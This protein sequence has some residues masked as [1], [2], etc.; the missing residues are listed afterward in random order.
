VTTLSQLDYTPYQNR[1]IAVVNDRVVGVG[2]NADQAYRSAKQVRPKDRPQLLFVDEAGQAHIQPDNLGQWFENERLKQIALILQSQSA[3]VYLVGGAV[4][5]GLLGRLDA[6]ADLDLVAPAGAL[7]LARLLADRLKAAYYPV[8]PDREVGRVVF[9]DRTHIDVATYRG[10]S[11]LEDL[12]LRDFTINAIALKLD[13]TDLKIIDPL[14]GQADLKQ[15][16]IR[17]ASETAL[18]DD[19]LRAIRA[20]RLAAQFDF[21]I[22]P[23]TQTWVSG[24]AGRL[25]GVSVERL[26]DEALKLLQVGRPGQALAQLKALGLLAEIMPEA[27]AMVGV[28]QSSPHYLPVF[29]HTLDVMDW[30]RRL[31][32]DEPRLAFLDPLKPELQAYLQSEL[33]GNL[34]RAA[35]LPLAALCHDIGKPQ[36]ATTGSDGRIH[37]WRHP[38]RGAEIAA[39]VMT[40]WRFSTQATRFVTTL[41]R[42]HMRPLLLA[43]QKPV[44]KRAIYRF[45]AAAADAAPAIAI[46]SL[47]DHLGTYAPGR[48]ET[49]WERLTEVVLQLCQAYFTPKPQPLLT[50]GEVIR[51]LQL[52]PGPL[53]GQL[54]REL[55]EAQAIGQVTSRAEALV[56][57]EQRMAKVRSG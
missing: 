22:T 16:V 24:Q 41:V 38:Q 39:Q 42:H 54:L 48:G 45:L 15:K 37:F 30:T 7:S 52:T 55:K 26:R 50:G 12:S 49:E 29:E 32:L 8:D 40:R 43:W 27:M 10:R 2:H 34:S 23:E 17:A 36:T 56:F 6:V 4:R 28:A 33:A 3:E 46:F 5:D 31:A 20:V 1:W 13:L 53:V 21:S 18:Q 35:L 9:P 51:H 14:S 25:K 44:S 19:P 47:C 11:L 57:V